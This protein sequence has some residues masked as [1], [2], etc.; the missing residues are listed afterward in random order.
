MRVYGF[1]DGAAC[2]YYR[3]TMPLDMM[4]ANGHEAQTG[5]GWSEQAR[6]YDVIVGQRIG[7]VEGLFI[8]RRLRPTHKLVYET[9]DDM[10]TIDPSNI[11]A[12]I[13]HTPG[14]MDGIEQAIQ[15]SH[16][17]TVS[18][19]P[20]ADVVRKFHDNV[21]VLPNYIDANMFD[22]QRPRPEKLTVGWAGGDSHLRDIAMVAMQLRR[23]FSRNP[24][25][26]FHNIGSDYRQVC[27]LPGRFT[28]WRSNMFSYYRNIDFDI[29]IAPLAH[30]TFNNSKS[31]IKALEYAALGIPVVA[32]DEP[33]YRDFVLD[34]VTG[35]LV[36]E[37]HEWGR[38]LYQLTNDDAMRQEMGAKAKQHAANFTIQKNWHLWEDAY[39][40]LQ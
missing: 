30:T 26:E 20:L 22:I 36:R 8:W 40:R 4:A 15:V 13:D 17:V 19:E 24:H 12:H 37:E 2:G 28:G 1:H 9:D 25:V 10:W 33:P 23:F 6:D 11:R 38:R 21:V 31:H 34:G 18:T 7:K 39:R 29:G 5:C 14:L 3:I 35:F 16:M 27:G 32:S